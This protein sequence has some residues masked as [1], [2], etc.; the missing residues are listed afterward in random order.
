MG[1]AWV[2]QMDSDIQDLTTSFAQIIEDADR[3]GFTDDIKSLRYRSIV[4]DP[5]ELLQLCQEVEQMN[6]G[7]LFTS[8][9]KTDEVWVLAVMRYDHMWA[10]HLYAKIESNAEPYTEKRETA[11]K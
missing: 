6:V 5:S 2:C 11:A 1:K 8:L 3:T 9:E 7:I 4:G 10:A